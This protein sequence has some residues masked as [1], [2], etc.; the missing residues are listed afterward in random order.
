MENTKQNIAYMVCIHKGLRRKSSDLFR[1]VS[2]IKRTTKPTKCESSLGAHTFCW[3]CHAPAYIWNHKRTDDCNRGTA[4]ERS[5]GKLL[6]VGRW[7]CLII[8]T[9]TKPQSQAKK[10]KRQGWTEVLIIR[11]IGISVLNAFTPAFLMCNLLS[12]GSGRS[13]FANRVWIKNPIWVC[14][15]CKGIWFDLQSWKG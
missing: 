10:A 9:R 14:T 8:F 6:G 7:G 5:V 12:L 2:Q 13:I 4:L 15:V 11:R 3:F 1:S